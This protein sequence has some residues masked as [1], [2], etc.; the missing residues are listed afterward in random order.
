M[1]TGVRQNCLLSPLLFLLVVDWIMRTTTEGARTDIQW[2]L[3]SQLHD[4]D[5]ADD[6]ALLSYTHQHAQAN[7]Q[8]LASTAKLK[9]LN[10]KRSKAKVMRVNH[11]PITL[12][13][14]AL[15][16][17]SFFTYLGSVISTDGGSEQDA[18]AKIGK[19]RSAFLLLRPI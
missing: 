18:Q 7:V 13:N 3:T 17:V 1:K 19:A 12:D 2:T 8:S 5:V 10:T 4:L 9:G 11:D 15:E 6:V 16:E 14:E